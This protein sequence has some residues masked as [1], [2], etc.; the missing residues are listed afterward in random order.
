M[1]PNEL[2][3]FLSKVYNEEGIIACCDAIIETEQAKND[4][5]TQLT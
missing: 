1:P 5:E 4:T 3:E 2:R